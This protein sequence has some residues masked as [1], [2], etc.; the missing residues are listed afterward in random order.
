S[1]AWGR[2]RGLDAFEALA[3]PGVF[4]FDLSKGEAVL[5]LS[6]EAPHGEDDAA[7]IARRLRSEEKRR[8]FAFSSRLERAADDYIVRRGDGRTIVAGHPWFTALG[9][10]TFTPLRPPSPPPPP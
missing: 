7:V 8:R 1:S 2:G 4:R 6:S 3:S 10:D 5:L 9:R